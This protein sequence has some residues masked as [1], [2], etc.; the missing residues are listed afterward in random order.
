MQSTNQFR[1]RL[2]IFA[3]LIFLGAGAQAVV[4]F[5]QAT[6]TRMQNAVTYGDAVVKA[7]RP[8]QTGDVVKADNY[9]L[10][11]TDSRAEL[12]YADGS[13]VRIGQNTVFTFEA[14]TRTL[15]LEKGS[16]IF[17]IPKGQGGGTVRTAS[18]TAAITGT[19]GKVTP[20]MIAILEGEVRL[21]PSGRIVAAGS[22]AQMGSDGM[23]TIAPFDPTKAM[24]GKLMDFGGKIAGFDEASLITVA[25]Q[26]SNPVRGIMETMETTDRPGNYPGAQ[27]RFVPED[28]VRPSTSVRVPPPA[29]TPGQPD[30][31]Y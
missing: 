28:V 16:L 22:F 1:T 4:P 6:V 20:N 3:A 8:A 24:G 15:S 31:Q 17:Y 9:L 2:A 25:P 27:E 12:K 30:A 7:R 11:E 18:I 5:S 29:S 10:T 13:L 19:I 26:F 14:D 23:I 21:V